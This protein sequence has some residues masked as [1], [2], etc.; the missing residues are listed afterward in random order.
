M[1]VYIYVKQMTNLI[2]KPTVTLPFPNV[3]RTGTDISVD[4]LKL[5]YDNAREEYIKERFFEGHVPSNI[6]QLHPIIIKF[7]GA[8][9]KKP[10]SLTLHVSS[11]YLSLG[12]DLDY[13]RC[14]ISPLT[15][16]TIVDSVNCVLPTIFVVDQIWQQADIK[17]TPRPWGPPYNSSMMS[18]DRI[19]KHSHRIDEQLEKYTQYVLK[20]NLLAGHKKDVVITNKLKE[21]PN[22][23]AIYGWQ[24]YRGIPIQKLY[25]GHANFYKDYSHGI[26]LVHRE[27]WTDTD[28]CIDILD[29]MKD[30][31]LFPAFN[32]E[33]V[34]VFRQP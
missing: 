11:D 7:I 21:K 8:I 4:L 2:F 34:T 18:S 17:L 28:M 31:E 6:R 27:V 15:A 32:S 9:S 30:Q 25:L 1:E 24:D 22:A 10:R 23:V 13:V 20:D 26:R 29:A 3:H 5:G 19:V 33:P 16:Q 12:N 14:P